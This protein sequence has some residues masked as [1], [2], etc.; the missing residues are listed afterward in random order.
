MFLRYFVSRAFRLTLVCHGMT[1][2]SRAAGF[3]DDE[4]LADGE[5]AK[6]AEIAPLLARAEHVSSAPALCARQTAEALSLDFGIDPA[7]RDMSYGRWAGR[8]LTEINAEAPDDLARWI[9][10]TDAAPHGGESI[11]ELLG[12]V[13]AWMDAHLASG[14][15][16]IVVTHAAVIRAMVLTTLGAPA[17]AFWKIDVEHL[18]LTDIRSDGRR[19]ALRSHGRMLQPRQS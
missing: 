4:P 7:F 10:D 18:S 2:A 8:T 12:R 13:S 11:C 9:T 14:G 6:A 3:P 19:W 15:H 5:A 16:R 17:E 1:T